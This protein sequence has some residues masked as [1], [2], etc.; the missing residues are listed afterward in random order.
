MR[1][2]LADLLKRGKVAG[3]AKWP[4]RSG[5]AAGTGDLRHWRG[6]RSGQA[7]SEACF[8][9]N[10]R[11]GRNFTVQDWDA[12]NEYARE[13][14]LRHEFLREFRA[15]LGIVLAG[16]RSVGYD[17]P[18]SDYDFLVLCDGRTFEQVA[19]LTG[20]RRD[21]KGIRLPVDDA[22]NRERF[23]IGVDVAVYEKE[24]VA[25]A[26]KAY[27]DIVIWIWTNA[28]TI[29]DPMGCVESLQGE[30]DGYPSEVL[31]AKL[32][33]HFLLDFHLSVHGITYR[34]ESQNVFSVA[35]ALAGKVA[36]FC[37]L[38]CLLDGKPFPYEKW[39]LKACAETATG[40]KILP[41]LEQV[42]TG[43]TRLEGDLVANAASVKKAV[44]LL[45][46]EACDI[47]EDA[48]VDWGI[49]QQWIKDAYGLL[50]EVIF[51]EW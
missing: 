7:R 10:V 44:R 41:L 51:E 28:K 37:K 9:M 8:Q 50:E 21:I 30:F 46:T 16:S 23:G 25:Q 17:V 32:K 26:F 36:E 2:K 18:S 19:V 33:K 3:R 6:G 42:V 12:I 31:E 35:Y 1:I 15:E 47:L 20:S 13:I 22:A 38:C 39:L 29:A 4:Q 45:D 27:R 40:Q 5:R 49:D 14:V 48:L 43:I 24:R 34:Y 11:G